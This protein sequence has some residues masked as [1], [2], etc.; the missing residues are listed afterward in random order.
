MMS[1]DYRVETTP[2][3]EREFK[4]LD[5]VAARRVRRKIDYLAANPELIS[6]PLRNPPSDLIGIH[7]YR[8]GDFRLLLWVDHRNRVIT[9]HAVG[10]RSEVYRKL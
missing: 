10:H 2:N 5:P 4:D 8:I 1:A 6:Q 9:L 3:F 7:K